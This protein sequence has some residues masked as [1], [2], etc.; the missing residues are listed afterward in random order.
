ML[1]LR[2]VESFRAVMIAGTAT[3]AAEMLCISQPAVSRML[4]DLEH[5]IGFKLFT[6]ANRK[7]I[8]TDEGRAFYEEVERALVGLDQIMEAAHAIREYRSGY[9]R[10]ITIPSLASTVMADL[11]ATFI[12]RYPLVSVSLEVQPSQR[13]FEWI[14]SQQ[15]DIGL[16]TVPFENPAITIQPVSSGDAVCILP[17][18]HPLTS[19]AEIRPSDLEGVSF[20]SFKADSLFRH[21]IDDVFQKAGVRRDLKLEARSTEAIYGLVAAGLGVSVIGPAFPGDELHN[22]IVIR[23]FKPRISIELAL[24]Y[25]AHKPLSRLA[26]CF[27]KIVDEFINNPESEFTRP[28]NPIKSQANV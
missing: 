22:G 21:Q 10:L 2:Q 26:E 16:S 1:T 6:R 23:P 28:G 20:V 15:C 14:V 3:Q 11:V 4:S 25:S 5:K 8:P 18:N 17:K 7:L 24:L 12:K 9:F 19:R 27:V 13:V